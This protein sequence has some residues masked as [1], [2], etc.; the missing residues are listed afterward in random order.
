[1]SEKFLDTLK[2]ENYFSEAAVSTVGIPI[3]GVLEDKPPGHGGKIIQSYYV[4]LKLK[5]NKKLC[6]PNI[7]KSTFKALLTSIWKMELPPPRLCHVKSTGYP[8]GG[9]HDDTSWTC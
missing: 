6:F 9:G 2:F 4:F 1:M 3:P 5:V 7:L 8:G